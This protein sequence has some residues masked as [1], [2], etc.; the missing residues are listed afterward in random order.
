[1]RSVSEQF[2]TSSSNIS[3]I[4]RA[5]ALSSSSGEVNGMNKGMFFD[6]L[7][8]ETHKLLSQWRGRKPHGN[9][10][11]LVLLYRLME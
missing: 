10:P 5:R 9:R 8:T 6:W 3:V 1:M 7:G 4:T 2:C 11:L